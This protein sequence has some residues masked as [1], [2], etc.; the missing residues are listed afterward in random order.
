V[1]NITAT[2]YECN[3]YEATGIVQSNE[4]SGDRIEIRCVDIDESSATT[5]PPAN[6][7]IY[8]DGDSA[9]PL[10]DDPAAWWEGDLRNDTFRANQ[11]NSLI[12]GSDDLVLQS[13]QALV[14]FEFGSSAQG[15]KRLMMLY[16]IGVSDETMS[17]DVVDITVVTTDVEES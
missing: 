5:L 11:S 10:L 3:E 1:T 13:N 9:D 12:D 15:K 8:L 6:K 16:E 2:Q 17:T 4:T 14:V 7:S